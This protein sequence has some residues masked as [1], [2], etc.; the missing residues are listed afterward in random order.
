MDL[1]LSGD[2]FRGVLVGPPVGGY[3]A[4]W[5]QDDVSFWRL[6]GEPPSILC[7][8]AMLRVDDETGR[9]RELGMLDHD[10]GLLDLRDLEPGPGGAPVSQL[11][12]LTPATMEE[13]KEESLSGGVEVA[14]WLGEVALT[15]AGRGEWLA[16]H[17]GSWEGAAPIVVVELARD[18]DGAPRTEVRATPVPDDADFWSDHPVPH[19]AERQVIAVPASDKAFALSGPLILSAFLSWGMHPLL[20]GM[21]FGPNPLGSW[22]EFGAL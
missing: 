5:E 21:T 19:E 11:V 9:Y 14:S 4:L 12:A 22:S 2:G 13:A 3:I 18:A 7:A 8:G 16:V 15:A 17:E 6:P 10:S 20:L 1:D